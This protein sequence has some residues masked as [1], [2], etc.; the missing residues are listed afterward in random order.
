MLDTV[1]KNQTKV[2]A[3]NPMGYPPKVT[4][5]SRRGAARHARRQDD[6]SGRLPLRR[7]DRT[8]QADRGMVHQTHAERENEARL[9]VELLR[10]RRSHACGTRSRTT[11]IGAI[12]GVGHC[13]TCA[14]AV[15][16]HAITVDTKFGIPAVALHT[17]IFDRVVASTAPRAGARE[18][19]ARVRAAA[20]DGQVRGRTAG[21]C[22]RQGPCHR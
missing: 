14:P 2:T 6:L 1:N 12:L 18:C 22:G 3:L 9:A 11:A 10:S 17:H 21:L 5:K 16:T 19:A 13:S 4:K 15:T 20:G 8:A 7:L